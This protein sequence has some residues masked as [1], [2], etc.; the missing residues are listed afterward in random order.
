MQAAGRSSWKHLAVLIKEAGPTFSPLSPRPALLPS[1][2]NP[3]CAPTHFTYLPFREGHLA[4]LQLPA[5]TSMPQWTSLCMSS[6]EPAG[7]P[8]WG[9]WVI[10]PRPVVDQVL[11]G[12]SLVCTPCW[13]VHTSSECINVSL[14]PS[15]HLQ[16]LG[17]L[18]FVHL[19]AQNYKVVRLFF[20][21]FF[22]L[23]TRWAFSTY[24]VAILISSPMN[25]LFIAYVSCSIGFS[26]F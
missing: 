25:C 24:L 23:S 12:C 5:S 4:C 1:A 17:H 16:W 20:I 14:H 22:W 2:L 19:M 21:G 13:Y 18:I 11:P 9:C 7:K 8:F 6:C 15:Q 3:I 10:G 26:C